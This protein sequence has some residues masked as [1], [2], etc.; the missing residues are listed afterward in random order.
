V[1]RAILEYAIATNDPKLKAFVRDGYEWQ[2][3]VGF[4]KIGMIGDGQGCNCGR[5][6]G[7][8]VKMSYAGIG[9]YWEDVDQYIRNHGTE[10]QL[11]PED[12]PYLKKWGEGKPACPQQPNANSE[13]ALEASMGGFPGGPFKTDTNV[14][15]GPHGIMGIFYAWDGIIRYSDGVAQVNLLLNRAS[16]WMDIDSYLPYEGKV[17]LRNKTAKEA[18]VRIPLFVD[19]PTVKCRVG[20]RDVKLRWFGRY[21]QLKDLKTDDVITIEFPLMERIEKWTA[22][23]LVRPEWAHYDTPTVTYTCKFKGNT[24]IEISPEIMPGSPLYKGRAEKY[25]TDQAP[26]KKVTRFV[27]PLVLQW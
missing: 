23:G 4:A 24:L 21:V 12:G 11:T 8:A 18:L 6:I 22:P 17:V 16:P 7:L 3:Q 25:K 20:Q 9:D 1:L 2:R 15:C 5:L 26:I 27:T 14:C 13:G 19:K 10:Y